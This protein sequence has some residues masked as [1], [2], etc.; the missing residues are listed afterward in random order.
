[1]AINIGQ[2]HSNLVKN[3]CMIELCDVKSNIEMLYY[4]HVFRY[5]SLFNASG[6][7]MMSK[8]YLSE[9][10][11]YSII[12]LSNNLAETI[13]SLKKINVKLSYDNLE[14]DKCKCG[15]IMTLSET[16]LEFMCPKCG[17]LNPFNGIVSNKAIK[18]NGR[19]VVLHNNYKHKVYKNNVYRS[20][21]AM[22]NFEFEVDKLTVIKANMKDYCE[23]EEIK[24]INLRITW[25]RKEL[26][27]NGL[28]SWFPHVNLLKQQLTGFII[29]RPTNIEEEKINMLYNVYQ[30][31]YSSCYKKEKKRS[32]M[33]CEYVIYKIIE[34]V[35]IDNHKRRTI[36]SHISLPKKDT[37]ITLDLKY[38]HLC[39]ESNNILIYIPTIV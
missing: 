6:N 17:D 7:S 14:Y 4:N 30:V 33:R 34:Q 39:K 3:F 21:F 38:E 19:S 10:N 13:T 16:D 11:R 29:P 32:F 1:M 26:G 25:F 8:K 37:L 36:L 22:E 27:L 35:M 23:L 31:I 20:I 28:S 2:I 12:E 18:S 9:L 15:A 5:Y 24:P